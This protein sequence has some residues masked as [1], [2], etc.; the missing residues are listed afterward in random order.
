MAAASSFSVPP[1]T[2][3]STPSH[4]SP[5][6]PPPANSP[7]APPK[8]ASPPSPTPQHPPSSASAPPAEPTRIQHDTVSRDV[9]GSFSRRSTGRRALQPPKSEQPVLSRNSNR[10]GHRHSNTLGISRFD[11]NRIAGHYGPE[12]FGSFGVGIIVNRAWPLSISAFF[13]SFSSGKM[14]TGRALH[15][16][17]SESTSAT[18]SRNGFKHGAFL[19][20]SIVLLIASPFV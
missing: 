9:L 16:E 19:A 15:K 8:P 11:G 5:S 10:S 2:A 13:A 12:V 14:A 1:E 18:A 6:P 3:R 17:A 20:F 4:Y 7:P